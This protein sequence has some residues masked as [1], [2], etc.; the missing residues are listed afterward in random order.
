M[1]QV[2]A[3]QAAPMTSQ[4]ASRSSMRCRFTLK[5]ICKGACKRTVPRCSA[6]THCSR[7]NWTRVR[8]SPCVAFNTTHAVHMLESASRD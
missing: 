7:V 5:A 4:Q 2:M 3:G 6:G 1:V 8:H